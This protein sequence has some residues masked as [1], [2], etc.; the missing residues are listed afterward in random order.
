MITV[1][2][3]TT[4]AGISELRTQS[5]KILKNVRDHYVVLERHQK[6]VAVL[7][8]YRKFEVFEKMLDY[9]EDYIL[10]QLAKERDQHSKKSD[11]VDIDQW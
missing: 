9:A 11:F 2:S 6:P 5:D 1:K 3:K 4:I 7:I 10:G 8:D